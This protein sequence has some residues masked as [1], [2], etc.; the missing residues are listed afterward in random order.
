[1]LLGQAKLELLLGDPREDGRLFLLE[2]GHSVAHAL[3][4]A[5]Y[6]VHH[7]CAV[8]FGMMVEAYYAQM[9]GLLNNTF[10]L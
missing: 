7:G 10:F 4:K 9:T 3:E 8:A 6:N 2:V 5:A 1:M